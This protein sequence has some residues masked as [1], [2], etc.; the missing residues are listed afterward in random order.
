MSSFGL[1]RPAWRDVVLGVAGFLVGLLAFGASG[2]LVHAL[3]WGNT[4]DTIALLAR[5]PLPYR[6]AIVLTTGVTEEIIFRGYLLERVGALLH[7]LGL[8]AL[9]SLV[10]F[11]HVSFL[12]PQ[13]EGAD[14]CCH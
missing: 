12:K 4:G 6:I 5:I 1:Y 10:V 11:G 8:G 13:C 14:A 9:V 3:H 7:S 2:V